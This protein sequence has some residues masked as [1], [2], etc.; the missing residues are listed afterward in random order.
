MLDNVK[1]ED[2]LFLDIETVPAA[3]PSVSSILRC[4]HSGKK[5]QN[6]SEI[7]IRLRRMSMKGPGYILN[8]ER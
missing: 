5:N 2:I 7:P 3:P 6:N 4:N 1:I 8:S